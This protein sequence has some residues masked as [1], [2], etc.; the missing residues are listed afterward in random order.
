MKN[1][2]KKKFNNIDVNASAENKS[3]E[4]SALI[5]KQKE[6]PSKLSVKKGEKIITKE[7]AASGTVC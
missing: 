1:L 6:S 5:E 7:V 3:D 4:K 2:K